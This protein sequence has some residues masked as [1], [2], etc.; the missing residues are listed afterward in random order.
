MFVQRGRAHGNVQARFHQAQVHGGVRVGLRGA[1]LRQFHFVRNGV[2]MPLLQHAHQPLVQQRV[3]VV[4]AQCLGL[5]DGTRLVL[6]V[7]QVPGGQVEE[8]PAG[9]LALLRPGVAVAQQGHDAFQV[10]LAIKVGAA[11]VHAGGGQHVARTVGLRHALRPQSHHGEVGRAAADVHHQH[12]RLL[13][14]PPLVVQRSGDGLELEGNVPE[15]GG[16]RS[17]QQRLLGLRVACGVV[18]DKVHWPAQHHAFGR[19]AQCPRGA[20]VQLGQVGGD[21]VQKAHRPVVDDGAFLD[22]RTAQQALE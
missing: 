8:H 15:A 4:A 5:C 20:L 10:E 11:D 13:R 17:L 22:E 19:M 2:A 14:Q 18:V 16:L 7:D 3:A 1:D 21:D 12:Q 9:H 6:P